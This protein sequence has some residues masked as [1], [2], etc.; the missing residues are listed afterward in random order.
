MENVFVLLENILHT[1]F[2]YSF[3][4]ALAC[5]SFMNVTNLEQRLFQCVNQ[6]MHS[7][8]ACHIILCIFLIRNGCQIVKQQFI[9]HANLTIMLFWCVLLTIS[10]VNLSLIVSYVCTVKNHIPASIIL[11]NLILFGILFFLYN[12]LKP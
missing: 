10:Q 9:H 11:E 7:L 12:F 2:P 1:F 6:S 4:V 5:L 8:K 3:K